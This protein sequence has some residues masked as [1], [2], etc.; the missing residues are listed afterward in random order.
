MITQIRRMLKSKAVKTL[1]ILI[2]AAVGGVFTLPLIFRRTT[3][4]PWIATVNGKSV[5]YNAFVRK[6][7]ENE[8]QI[9]AFRAQYGELADALVQA[10]GLSLNPRV[11]AANQ[12]LQEE[13]IDQLADKFDLHMNKDYIADILSDVG[14]VYRNLSHLVPP[15][16]LDPEGGIDMQ[17][18][19]VY[20]ARQGMTIADFEYEVEQMLKRSLVVNLMLGAAYDPLWIVKER[21]IR[22]YA[23]RGFSVFRFDFTNYL[24]EAKKKDVS[25]AQL[26]DFFDSQNAQVKRYWVP[27]K[28]GGKV[29]EF[30]SES[31]GVKVDH[32]EIK[33]YYD[34][35]KQ[36]KFVEKPVKL[37]VR[38]ILI[39]FDKPGQEKSAY[40]KARG[41]HAE[42]AA[43]P[44][45]F[46]A[47]AKELSDDKETASKGGLLPEFSRG[48]YSRDFEKAAFLLRNDGDISAVVRTERGFEII[49]RENRIPAVVKS[50]NSVREDIKKTLVSKKFND[51]FYRDMKRLLRDDTLDSGEREVT[52][53]KARSTKEVKPQEKTDT[54]LSRALFGGAKDTFRFYSE[55]GKGFVVQITKIEKRYLPSIES[56]EDS[57]KG[58]YYEMHAAKLLKKD[59]EKAEKNLRAGGSAEQLKEDFN[60]T[61]E[62][63]GMITLADEQK[64]KRL[65]EKGMPLEVMLKLERVGAVGT[66]QGES[67]GMLFVLDAIEPFDQKDFLQ[68]EPE[69]RKTLREESVQL[70]LASLVAFLRK[71]AKIKVN[72][73]IINLGK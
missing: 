19:K 15:S 63:T 21:Y 58:D 1:L 50:L 31:Y 35:N 46:E 30:D 39:A 22:D 40:E 20:L 32:E 3:S 44:A 62:K 37:K 33:T 29:W 8:R 4:G 48:T 72:K 54:K 73:S 56:I 65:R 5:S 71:K 27:E 61:A 34:D 43:N 26:K 18:L 57:V 11:L 66:F 42:L 9:R 38:V 45:L 55:G 13:L 41:L 60:V 2:V 12:L 17:G 68:K 69:V 47:K 59:L 53:G 16:L 14:F 6:T 64:I 49:K 23:G 51:R 67:D 25:S 52:L 24:N 36:R 7:M 28:R 70:T 10:M